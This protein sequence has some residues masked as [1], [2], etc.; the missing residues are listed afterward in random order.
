MKIMDDVQTIQEAERWY[1]E[2]RNRDIRGVGGVY[3]E[4]DIDGRYPFHHY[5]PN[6][7]ILSVWLF[8]WQ[9]YAEKLRELLSKATGEPYDTHVWEMCNDNE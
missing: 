1:R 5:D 6:E 8:Q 4:Y 9:Q 7:L 2:C 3:S